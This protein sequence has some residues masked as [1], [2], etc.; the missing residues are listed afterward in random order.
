MH[1]WFVVSESTFDYFRA[2]RTYQE[3]HGKPVVLSRLQRAAQSNYGADQDR[4]SC[5]PRS[6]HHLPVAGHE[7]PPRVNDQP[8]FWLPA[9]SYRVRNIL[10]LWPKWWRIAFAAWEFKP[11]SEGCR[12]TCLA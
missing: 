6:L 5:E 7:K 3:S 4:E 12:L 2:M 8:R 11:V 10:S 9:A 1:L